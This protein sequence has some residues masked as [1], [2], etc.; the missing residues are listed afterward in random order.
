[1]GS[2]RTKQRRRLGRRTGRSGALQVGNHSTTDAHQFIRRNCKIVV[3][4][5]GCCPH[6]VVLQQ[7]GIDEDA[8]LTAVAKRGH[9]TYGFGNL[10]PQA[11]PRLA[12]Q[13][14]F[15]KGPVLGISDRDL[16]GNR[17]VVSSL[18]RI[19]QRGKR[20]RQCLVGV[21]EIEVDQ[22]G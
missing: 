13:V 21:S 17:Q 22:A 12:S 19:S 1:M 9:A 5:P 18:L 10:L 3:P 15:N 8:Q 14:G 11:E 7:I 2:A 16:A 20:A 6:L 4:R